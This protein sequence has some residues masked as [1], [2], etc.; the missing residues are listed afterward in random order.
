MSSKKVQRGT[1]KNDMFDGLKGYGVVA[2]GQGDDTY[3]Y[4]A[5]DGSVTI[6]ETPGKKSADTLSLKNFSMDDVA[7]IRDGHSLKIVV[8]DTGDVI[9]L[10]GQFRDGFGVDKITFA[11]GSSLDLTAIADLAGENAGL[12]INEK[13]GLIKGDGNANTLFNMDKFGRLAGGHGSDTYVVEAGHGDVT[14]REGANRGDADVLDLSGLSS[15]DV[16]LAK[17]GNHLVVTLLATGEK[18]V[19][20]NHFTG[21]DGSGGVEKLVLD[22]VTLDDNGIA[23]VAENGWPQVEVLQIA[24]L[25]EGNLLKNGSFDDFAIGANRAAWVQAWGTNPF[26]V[27]VN[28]SHLGGWDSS[29]ARGL[30]ELWQSGFNGRAAHDGGQFLELNAN[31]NASLSQTV[32]VKGG[33]HF[34]L[35]FAHSGRSGTDTMKVVVTD[36]AT[37]KVV[38][39]GVYSTGKAW[40]EYTAKFST[41]ASTTS[42]SVTFTAVDTYGHN[43]SVGNLLDGI[44]LNYVAAPELAVVMGTDQGDDLQATDAAERVF[45]LDG[46]DF[47]YGNGGDDVIDAGGGLDTI[48]GGAG[49]DTFVYAGDSGRDYIIDFAAGEDRVMIGS[50]LIGDG[51]SAM[52]YAYQDGK[53]VIFEFGEKVLVL[54]GKNIADIDESMFEVFNDQ[55]GVAGLTVTG[56]AGD[57]KL[58][59]GYGDDTLFG[60]AGFDDIRGSHGAD[61]YIFGAGS[62]RDFLVDFNV[63]HDT[64]RIDA[65][66]IAAGKTVWDYVYENEG[67]TV[68][69][70]NGS[71]AIVLWR[72]GVDTLN[73]SVFSFV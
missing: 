13:W 15:T 8:R 48:W 18:V 24:A 54:W 20:T 65:S 43:V 70:F 56:T 34:E 46:A 55:G 10:A 44:D 52:D 14:I 28:E 25:Q 16:S 42:L 30:A 7:F 39:E 45:G 6:W 64:L 41:D 35:D 73:D 22:D 59:G 4:K 66:L 62:D 31:S 29:D 51:K 32:S 33:A 3:V 50:S 23:D 19:V 61:T 36:A 63:D 47:V 38:F 57:D 49:A 40:T 21:S 60:G 1:G 5:G 26:A 58:T 68:I 37:G 72:V 12:R 27:H 2:G 11:D 17:S 67:S 53:S 69:D 9:K 71:D